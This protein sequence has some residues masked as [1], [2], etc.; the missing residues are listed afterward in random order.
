MAQNR[1][2]LD[3]SLE[4]A[5]ERKHF[6]D[7]YIEQFNDE[8]GVSTLTTSELETIANYLLWGK[9]KSGKPLGA[10]TQLETKWTKTNDIESLDSLLESTT[11]TDLHIYG[12]NEATSYRKP[13]VVFDR[14][15]VRRSAP[16]HLIGVFEDLWR[17]ID[18]VDLLINFY[19]L[20]IGKRKNP[21]RESLL[22]RFSAADLDDLEARALHLNQYQYLKLRHSLVEL[23]REQFSLQ[24]SYLATLNPIAHTPAPKSNSS[25]TFDVDIE[26]L[27]LGVKEGP[28]EN[29]IFTTN[30]APAHLTTKQ[31]WAISDL[32]QH[33]H[34]VEQLNLKKFDFRELE[35]VYQLYLY[36]EELLDQVE[37][38]KD[39]HFLD[40]NIDKLIETLDFYEQLADLT[41]VQREILELK[42][43]HF[44]NQDIAT[45]INKKYGKS[46]TANYISTIFR[47]KIISKINEAAALHRESVENFFY[48]ENFKKCT[49][50]GRLLLLDGRNWV[51]K[52]RSKDGFQNRCKRC[53]RESR[54]KKK[55]K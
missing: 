39:A 19:E 27:P 55:E 4:T 22:K 50:C 5:E 41:D 24:D 30:Y 45:T 9:D 46:Y 48:P 14:Q 17:Q 53:E 25:I 33:K 6:I 52:S 13:R 47:Q 11:F 37:L 18:E 44:K 29:L 51:R 36:K 10:E 20:R 26:V 28:L 40:S 7:R 32:L 31:L 38:E 43:R 16:P 3:F 49:D 34:K 2:K 15:K 42:T 21:P 35:H 23:R 54:A 8:N 1:L 12:L